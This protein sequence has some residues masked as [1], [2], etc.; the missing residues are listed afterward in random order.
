MRNGMG[1]VEEGEEA[2]RD[3]DT[4]RG[5]AEKKKEEPDGRGII[6][7]GGMQGNGRERN[8]KGPPLSPITSAPSPIQRRRESCARCKEEEEEDRG[9]LCCQKNLARLPRLPPP[10]WLC[11]LAPT[12]TPPSFQCLVGTEGGGR[13]LCSGTANLAEN[14]AEGAGRCGSGASSSSTGLRPKSAPNWVA[15]NAGPAMHPKSASASQFVRP[16]PSSV[17]TAEMKRDHE[18]QIGKGPCHT[19]PYHD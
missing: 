6:R 10:L 18:R 19:M 8:R 15:M 9:W 13:S 2:D 5:R 17:P 7:I 12:H 14:L 3:R 11:V 1:V 4:T 16:P